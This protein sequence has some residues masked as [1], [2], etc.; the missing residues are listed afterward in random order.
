MPTF[1]KGPAITQEKNFRIFQKLIGSSTHYPY[2]PIKFQQLKYY[3]KYLAYK[4]SVQFFSKG[5]NSRKGHNPHKKKKK[6]Y[7]F[8]M[9]NPYMK[10]QKSSMDG[11]K[12]MLCT[13]KRD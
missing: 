11:S 8:F 7:Y 2:Q 3:L 6:V 5:H 1:F 13:K 4:I 9:R 10:F 12:V